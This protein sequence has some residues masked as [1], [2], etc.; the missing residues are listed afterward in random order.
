MWKYTLVFLLILLT[1]VSANRKEN[2]IPSILEVIEVLEDSM[3]NKEISLNNKFNQSPQNFTTITTTLG[4]VVGVEENGYRVFKGIPYASPP[5]GNY[6]WMP[7]R[8]PVAWN[9]VLNATEFPVMCPQHTGSSSVS[10][11]CLYLNVWT[12]LS[13]NLGNKTVPV[14]VWIHGGDFWIG[15]SGDSNFWGI[16]WLIR[17]KIL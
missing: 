9:G 5:T 14:M 1:C 13:E 17:Q 3:R 16:I 11:D 12:P 7:P 8:P 4:T 10:E 15:W 2:E 6:R